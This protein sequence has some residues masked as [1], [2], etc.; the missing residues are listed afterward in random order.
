M[1]V[2]L[3]LLLLPTGLY[4]QPRPLG[5]NLT[6][7]TDYST[8]LVFTDAMRSARGWITFNAAGSSPW[9]TQLPIP[10][11]ANGYPTHVPF[12]VEGQPAQAV[13]TV[14]LWDLQ[15]HYP[16]GTYRLMA[17]G[18]GSISLSGAARGTFVSPVDTLITVNAAQGGIILSIL[19]SEVQDPVHDIRLLLPDYVRT[20]SR[21]FTQ[22]FLDF[23]APFEAIRY[24]DWLRTNNSTVQRWEDRTRPDFFTQAARTGVSWE[25]IVELANLTQKDL[26]ICIPH[27]AT[28][29]YVQHLATYLRDAV[30]PNLK[31]YIE[32]SN[33]VWNGIFQQHAWARERGRE[34]FGFANDFQNVF[35]FVVARSAEIFHT[36][37]TVFGGT[38][39]MVR[40]LPSWTA[41]EGWYTRQLL[42]LFQDPAY[43]PHGVGVDAVATAPYF[44]GS[45][46]DDLVRDGRFPGATVNEVVDSLWTSLPS[47]LRGMETAASAARSFGVQ[48]LAYEGGQHLVGTG[49]N[50]SNNAL[51]EL[52]VAA[53]RDPAL[54]DLY[55]A[56]FNNWYDRAQGG[57]FAVFS[58]HGLPSRWGSWGLKEHMN[59]L[60]NPKYRAVMECVAARN[61]PTTTLTH[62]FAPE[63]IT[64]DGP[65]PVRETLRLREVFTAGSDVQVALFDVLGRRVL[66]QTFAAKDEIAVDVHALPPGLYGLSVQNGQ[67]S[68]TRTVVLAGPR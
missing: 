5:I 55:C 67:S 12:D 42:T 40:V 6:A 53:N 7:V 56:Y 19:R 15:G 66:H 47:A 30:D 26:W 4:A 59:D 62:T 64:L 65:H 36:F 43:N 13:R 27:R 57:L 28:D 32:Y 46:A 1:R 51:T 16:S 9:D 33:E 22:P 31:L 29:E 63:T 48:L 34:R 35:T 49:A 14:L 2:L 20:P 41:T 17:S 58:S 21:T 61:V 25:H 39:R 24:M 23:L 45:V 54:Y 8:E 38:G 37:E 18:Q 3:F 68:L 52:L 11:L 50:T 44:G 60:Q 10:T